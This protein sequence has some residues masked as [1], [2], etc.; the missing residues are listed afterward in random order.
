MTFDLPG[1]RRLVLA[2]GQL[3][4]FWL[5]AGA[6]AVVLL[7]VLYREERRLV[8]R[9][10]GLGLLGLRVLAAV[11]LVAALFEPIAARTFREAVRGR[12]VVAVDVSE[13]MATAD[14]GRTGGER[15]GLVKVL[16]MSADRAARRDA[17]A[18]GRAEADRRPAGEARRPSTR[19]R[20]SPSPAT[21]PRRPPRPWPTRLRRPG[22]PDD[23]AAQTTDWR[24]VL[25]EA[26]K[27]ER[28]RRPGASAWCCV[29]DGRRNAPGDDAATVDRLA[30]RGVPVFP[31]L[32][33]S[34]R[35]PR[36][37]AVA[38]VKA[39]ESVYKGDVASVEVTL[40][41]DGYAGREVAVTLDRP[42]ASPLRQTARA[43]G[44]GSRPTVTFRVP[45]EE[46]GA[47]PLSV[48]VDP[49]EGDARPDNDR[50]TVT[51][52]VA[53]D[54]ARVLLVDGEA[55]WEFRYLRNAL[56]RDPRVDGRGGRLPPAQARPLGRRGVHLRPRP[57]PARPRRRRRPARRVRRR[58]R[59][60]PRP[61]RRDAR[62]LGAAGRL[63]RRAGRDA[64]RRARPAVVVG[65]GG[66]TRRRGSSC[67]CSTPGPPTV[68]RRRPTTPRTPAC[69]PASPFE[70]TEAAVADAGRLADAPARRRA[71]GV[72][73]TLGGPA[74]APLVAR[75][76]GQAGGDR[77]GDGRGRPVA[78]SSSP[79][80]RTGSAR[81][82]GS[83]PT[84]PGGGGTGSATRTTTGSGA[85]SC[86]GRP[87]GSSRRATP[88]SGS[89]RPGPAPARG[90]RSASRRGSARGSPGSA[91]TC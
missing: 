89:A 53:D 2:G 39:P 75:R 43:A 51:V 90:S 30:A 16:G 74:A 50:R 29:T 17:Q 54:K 38:A 40:K 37:A 58:G 28:R 18:R 52:Q 72:A 83:A 76:Q 45:L 57:A 10:A 71:R 79:R 86:A 19:S 35:P 36:D 44:D 63:R 32:V 33:G 25:A 26:L 4:G 88:S 78:A 42:G 46:V 82:S 12:V 47:V 22:K 23:P 67:R 7:L 34:T 65:A 55:R 66:R 8:S 49:Q 21:P 80:S 41:L 48:A 14:P 27:A 91:P 84:A 13:S 24:P 70:P 61:G 15:A 6:A 11:A 60:R 81:C 3:G 87:P 59:R 64:R 56:A 31:V 62:G 73:P 68:D 77:A 9:R 5:A 85:R 20:P 1:G 69:P